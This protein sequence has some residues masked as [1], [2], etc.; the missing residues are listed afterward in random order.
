MIIAYEL[1]YQPALEH[2]CWGTFPPSFGRILSKAVG[3]SSRRHGFLAS[4]TLENI[5]MNANY[6]NL[7][8]ID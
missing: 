3:H 5:S 6:N 4:A 7:D 1:L 8:A 2:S